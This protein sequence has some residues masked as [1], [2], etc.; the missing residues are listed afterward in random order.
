MAIQIIPYLICR[1][2]AA[3]IDFLT[4]AYG[5]VE[6]ERR[7]TPSGGIHAEMVLETQRIMMG[8]PADP[9]DMRPPADMPGTVA[10]AG[11]FVYLEDIDGHFE[12]ASAEGAEIIHPPKNVSY[13]RT[14]AAR[15][16]DG[17]PWF[18]TRPPKLSAA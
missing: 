18:F 6:E 14:Y 1:D 15:D 9:A 3:S 10:T 8:Q 12:R 5:F 11:I 2:I 16:L 13:G 4:R 7:E 17:H